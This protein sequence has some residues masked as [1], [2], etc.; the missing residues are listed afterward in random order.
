MPYADKEKQR[1]AQMLWAR[2]NRSVTNAHRTA[3]RGA[4]RKAVQVLK[5][6]TPCAD[7]GCLYPYPVMQFDHRDRNSKTDHVGRMVGKNARRGVVMEEIAKCDVVCANCHAMR[8]WE[9]GYK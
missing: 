4:T 2:R 5:E 7:C 9:R 1:V 8:E 6:S 3:C